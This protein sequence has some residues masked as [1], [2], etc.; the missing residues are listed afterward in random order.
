MSNRSIQNDRGDYRPAPPPPTPPSPDSQPPPQ[1]EGG[2]LQKILG[3][4]KLRDLDTGDLL[5][6]LLIFLLF[7]EGEDE[8]LLLALALV[9]I[10]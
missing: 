10:L 1:G 5:L 3:R 8:E 6:L 7:S 2:F 9:W 4:L